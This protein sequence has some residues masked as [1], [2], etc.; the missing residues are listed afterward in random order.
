MAVLGMAIPVFVLAQEAAKPQPKTAPF[1]AL[2][3][4]QMQDFNARIGK[5]NKEREQVTRALDAE[6]KIIQLEFQAWIAQQCKTLNNDQC[7][8]DVQSP[9]PGKWTFVLPE[10]KPATKP[11]DSKKE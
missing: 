9:D 3:V 7:S 4:Q 6:L 5:N 1:N 10:P 11:P 8:V 2:Q